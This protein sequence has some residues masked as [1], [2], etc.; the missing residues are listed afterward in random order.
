MKKIRLITIIT[1]MITLVFI[2]CEDSDSFPN[3]AIAGT[4][5]GT[6]SNSNDAKY[7]D[8]LKTED[9]AVANITIIGNNLIQVHLYDVEIDTTFIVNYY[10]D[11]DSVNV[12]FSG[13]DFESMYGH[14]LGQGHSNGGM[15]GD[16]KQNETEWMH[17]LNDEHQEGD[18]H[19]G[20][21]D[22]QNHTFSYQFTK[23]EA[24]LTH[25]LQFQGVKK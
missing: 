7:K 8:Y 22:M 17:H 24:G 16:M 13:D 3:S 2:G 9:E 1:I 10:D 11:M 15:M 19:Y 23:W 25:D 12:C 21:F 18:E 6:I 14:M 5:V 20:S 4:Y